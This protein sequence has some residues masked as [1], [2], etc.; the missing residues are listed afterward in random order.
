[1]P[2]QDDEI[3]DTKVKDAK[4]NPKKDSA[5]FR[6]KLDDKMKKERE[7]LAKEELEKSDWR[8]ELESII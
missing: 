3:I 1:M 4:M 5:M 8:K 2:Q 6:R 7:R